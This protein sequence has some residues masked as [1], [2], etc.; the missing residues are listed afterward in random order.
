MKWSRDNPFAPKDGSDPHPVWRREAGE[1]ERKRLWSHRFCTRQ[2][3]FEVWD[4]IREVYD[5]NR[6]GT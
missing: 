2:V 1:W 3:F 4:K 6:A 5:D